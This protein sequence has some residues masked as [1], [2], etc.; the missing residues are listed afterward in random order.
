M[1]YQN[2]SFYRKLEDFTNEH[3]TVQLQLGST[4]YVKEYDY[5]FFFAIPLIE[6]QN[7]A[8][9]LTVEDPEMKVSLLKVPIQVQH[10]NFI[11]Y[12]GILKPVP[13]GRVP[14]QC[15]KTLTELSPKRRFL[16]LDLALLTVSFILLLFIL[17]RRKTSSGEALQAKKNSQFKDNLPELNRRLQERHRFF[18]LN[19]NAVHVKSLFEDLIVEPEEK[20]NA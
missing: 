18:L 1:P 8:L 7:T 6:W 4:L 15:F 14:N 12:V 20:I 17:F 16:P 5:N 10:A 3:I 2:F 13:Y 9:S 19:Y 11:H